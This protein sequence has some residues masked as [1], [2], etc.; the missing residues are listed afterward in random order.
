MRENKLERRNKKRS[1]WMHNTLNSRYEE[2]GY[3]TL[4]PQLLR[5]PDFILTSVNKE[6]LHEWLQIIKPKREL[7]DCAAPLR[8]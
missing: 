3:H 1:M 2:E 4:F 8:S 6:K 7:A 5:Y